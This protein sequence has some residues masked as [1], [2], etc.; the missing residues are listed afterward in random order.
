M[1]LKTH[2]LAI[3]AFIAFHLLLEAAVFFMSVNLFLV[4]AQGIQQ[5]NLP[6][7]KYKDSVCTILTAGND[8]YTNIDV[9]LLLTIWD[10]ISGESTRLSVDWRKKLQ[11]NINHQKDLVLRVSE[12]PP[13][14]RRF[15]FVAL[16]WSETKKFNLFVLRIT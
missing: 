12:W 2:F 8:I 1:K 10:N 13:D 3:A 15:L 5:V 11:F 6:D 14:A 4:E 16:A 7:A 9:I